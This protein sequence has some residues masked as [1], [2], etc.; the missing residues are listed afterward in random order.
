MK[1]LVD[2]NALLVFE[3]LPLAKTPHN[4]KMQRAGVATSLVDLQLPPAADLERSKD[5]CYLAGARRQ[6]CVFVARRLQLE[7]G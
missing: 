2:S 3:Q 6:R 4:I 1:L 7:D 5:V